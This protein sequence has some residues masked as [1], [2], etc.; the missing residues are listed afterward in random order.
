[1][2]LSHKLCSPLLSLCVQD[3]KSEDELQVLEVS[4]II[5]LH[6]LQLAHFPLIRDHL[7]TEVDM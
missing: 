3:K 4:S 2:G 1:M 7:G 6:I 5:F